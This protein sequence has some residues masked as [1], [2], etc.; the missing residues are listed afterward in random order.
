MREELKERLLKHLNFLEAELREYQKFKRLTQDE[1]ANNRD[2][3]RNTERWI[4]N[5][6]NSSIDISKVILSLEEK[7]L[8]ENYKG[9]LSY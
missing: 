4:E 2:K 3:G 7:V 8:P 6:V 1:Y 9:I 5:I